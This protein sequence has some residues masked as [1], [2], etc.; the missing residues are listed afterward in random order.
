M[1][2]SELARSYTSLFTFGCSKSEIVC[3]SPRV[4][5]FM[6]WIGS[7]IRRLKLT[8]WPYELMKSWM[9]ENVFEMI[10]SSDNNGTESINDCWREFCQFMILFVLCHRI[11]TYHNI[12]KRFVYIFSIKIELSILKQYLLVV[13]N[14]KYVFNFCSI[15]T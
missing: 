12:Y 8:Y 10:R 11:N 2:G 9:S 4:F 13:F 1:F 6:Y 5:G 7:V 15:I 3:G 14:F